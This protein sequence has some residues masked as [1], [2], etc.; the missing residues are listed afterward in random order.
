[1]PPKQATRGTNA[2]KDA[3]A[4]KADSSKGRSA[5]A[6][7]EK[8]PRRKSTKD[9]DEKKKE[10]Q[11]P[12]RRRTEREEKTTTAQSGG[13]TTPPRRKPVK[14][15]KEE[16]GKSTKTTKNAPLKEK[17]SADSEVTP[18]S[19]ML[20]MKV[21]HID[22]PDGVIT[23]EAIRLS[24]T[25]SVLDAAE[26]IVGLLTAFKLQF[27]K[28]PRL[29]A[30]EVKQGLTLFKADKLCELTTLLFFKPASN[31]SL[32]RDQWEANTS[33]TGRGFVVSPAF[34]SEPVSMPVMH[35]GPVTRSWSK[36][37]VGKDLPTITPGTR[38]TLGVIS[39]HQYVDETSLWK[40]KKGFG[41]FSANKYDELECIKW[42]HETASEKKTFG[43]GAVVYTSGNHVQYG[44]LT[45]NLDVYADFKGDKPPEIQCDR[46]VIECKGTTGDM[47]GHF[48]T[49]TQQTKDGFPY[50]EVKP[51]HLYVFQVQ[52]YMYIL[53][54][55]AK[56]TKSTPMRKAAMVLRHYNPGGQPQQDFWLSL[57]DSDVQT[58]RDIDKLRLFLQTH[59]LA[60]YIA[61][62]RQ[63][64]VK[65]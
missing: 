38:K 40:A 35:T 63:L 26:K 17:V 14:Q 51:K 3:V 39:N 43:G 11:A 8:A 15:E 58:Q 20:L 47:V 9:E 12:A 31:K 13:G 46:L 7:K 53:N 1:M 65:E 4:A 24:E 28:R 34:R 55:V 33:N 32:L 50:A 27:E 23:H 10:R 21:L 61:V 48:F 49:K 62:L 2:S 37:T 5:D 54:A 6:E 16:E 57:V 45:G 19:F 52:T 56:M 44:F 42:F 60:C 30:R 41:M 29:S 64:F 25:G 22:I 59:V 18:E 36:L